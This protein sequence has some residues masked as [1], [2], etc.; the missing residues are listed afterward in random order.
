MMRRTATILAV[1]IGAQ[2]NAAIAAELPVRTAAQAIAIAKAFCIKSGPKLLDEDMNET[3]IR[4]AMP[5]LKWAASK[6]KNEWHVDT[7]GSVMAGTNTHLLAVD[8]PEDGSPPKQCWD[9]LYTL[10]GPPP[11]KPPRGSCAPSDLS[12]ANASELAFEAYQRG[13]WVGGIMATKPQSEPDAWIV[14]IRVAAPPNTD[15]EELGLYKVFK[16]TANVQNVKTGEEL[17]SLPSKAHFVELHCLDGP[18]SAK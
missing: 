4:D 10:V 14:S 2:S 9:S 1:M 12:A 11:K 17:N 8:V 7:M 3:T 18:I 16:R 6:E 15:S 5:T 13:V